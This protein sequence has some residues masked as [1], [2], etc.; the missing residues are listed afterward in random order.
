MKQRVTDYRELALFDQ[1]E[2]KNLRTILHCLH[3]YEITYR[4]GEILIMD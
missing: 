2:E 4:K 3:S 1:L